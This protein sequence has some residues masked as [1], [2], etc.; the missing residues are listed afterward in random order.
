MSQTILADAFSDD[1]ASIERP[2]HARTNSFARV[3]MGLSSSQDR[4]PAASLRALEDRTFALAK[5]V[6]DVDGREVHSQ[7]E[8]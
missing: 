3:F 1:I 4:F 2:E 6:L 5:C 8:G 7:V